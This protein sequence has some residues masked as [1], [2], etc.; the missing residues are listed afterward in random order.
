VVYLIHKIIREENNM[1]KCVKDNKF[2]VA[3]LKF[4]ACGTVTCIH[5]IDNKCM[6][7]NCEMYE[8]AFR[9]EY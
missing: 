4:K 9:Q 7:K 1:N 3:K 6:L 8:R 2:D 5:N